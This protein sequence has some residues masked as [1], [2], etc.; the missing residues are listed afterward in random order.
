[1]SQDPIEDCLGIPIVFQWYSNGIQA[2]CHSLIFRFL[3]Q[4]NGEKP[5]TCTHTPMQCIGSF[6]HVGTNYVHAP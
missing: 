5:F 3:K 6:A 1:M 4:G 2:I